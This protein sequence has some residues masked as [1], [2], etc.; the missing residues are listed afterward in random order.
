[1]ELPCNNTV[2]CCIF[3]LVHYFLTEGTKSLFEPL[4]PKAR[5]PFP[6][7]RSDSFDENSDFKLQL[8]GPAWPA[9]IVLFLSQWR[10]FMAFWSGPDPCWGHLCHTV[11]N[12]GFWPTESPV[13][14]PGRLAS[15]VICFLPSSLCG[16]A[17][18]RVSPY[19]LVCYRTLPLCPYLSLQRRAA[20]RRGGGGLHK[21]N[22]EDVGV[23]ASSVR[24]R[25]PSVWRGVP[26]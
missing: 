15:Q 21:A 26:Y 25:R 8:P 20:I 10:C 24:L 11:S 17:C 2:H 22:K 5:R 18:R 4:R 1:M 9:V 6:A 19:F 16:I 12:K 23:A 13:C 7:F 14:S 3:H